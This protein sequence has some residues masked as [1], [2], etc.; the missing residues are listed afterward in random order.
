M[1]CPMKPFNPLDDDDDYTPFEEFSETLKQ[2]WVVAIG[3]IL[4]ALVIGGA[5]WMGS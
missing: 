5:V 3:I 4:A 1:S 2:V